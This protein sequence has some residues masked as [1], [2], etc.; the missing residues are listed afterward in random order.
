MN[1]KFLKIMFAVVLSIF[2]FGKANAALLLV[3]DSNNVE[4][5]LVG[6][7][8]LSDGDFWDDVNNCDALADPIGCDYV[9]AK[10]LNGLEAAQRIFG[11]LSTGV[12]ATST[13][14]LFVN[15]KAWYD[16]VGGAVRALDQGIVADFNGDGFYSMSG[17]FSAY[18]Q[19]SF[20]QGTNPLKTET[21]V[22]RTFSPAVNVAS[23]S[24]LALSLLAMLALGVRRITRVSM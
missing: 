6:S 23:P 10:P 4:W 17:D 11:S 3:S 18:V 20:R 12:Y 9:N 8:F 24:V 7:F 22:F 14:A 19:D 2:M 21:F 15:N 5:E 13:D 16:A 1:S